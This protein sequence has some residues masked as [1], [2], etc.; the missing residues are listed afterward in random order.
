MSSSL[1]MSLEALKADHAFLT[2][3]GVFSEDMIEAYIELKET[4]IQRLNATTHPVEFEMYY[5]L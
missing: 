2:A 4:E 5:S 1:E 3:G